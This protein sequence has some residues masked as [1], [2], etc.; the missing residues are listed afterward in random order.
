MADLFLVFLRYIAGKDILPFCG[1]PFICFMVSF[2]VWKLFNF[3]RSHLLVA[4]LIFC[5]PR[6]IFRMSLSSPESCH[7]LLTFSFRLWN[8]MLMS[9]IQLEVSFCRFLGLRIYLQ[10]SVYWN[11]CIPALFVEDSASFLYIL[12][13]FIKGYV[14]VVFRFI[15]ES[16]FYFIDLCSPLLVSCCFHYNSS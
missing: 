8:L 3:M 13:I 6:V 5:A 1:L 15:S 16:S 7:V 12:G 10:F 2:A 11:P 4:G 9:L 14:A